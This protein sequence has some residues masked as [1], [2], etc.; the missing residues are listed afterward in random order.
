[1]YLH[2][3]ACCCSLLMMAKDVSMENHLSPE[4]LKE[5]YKEAKHST[6]GVIVGIGEGYFDPTVQGEVIHHNKAQQSKDK[7]NVSKK[8]SDIRK[9]ASVSCTQKGSCV[10]T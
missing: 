1:M 3:L 8:K 4:E 7:A 6:S 9:L 5:R 10:N 2:R